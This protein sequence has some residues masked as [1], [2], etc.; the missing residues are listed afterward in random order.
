MTRQH[1]FLWTDLETTGLVPGRDAI[2]EFACILAADDREGDM[3]IIEEFTGVLRFTREARDRVLPDQFVQKMHEANG[4]W[5]EC[6]ASDTTLAEVEEFFLETFADGGKKKGIVLAGNSVHFDHK[7]LCAHMPKF[8]GCLSHRVFDVSTLSAAAMAWIGDFQP[9]R[10]K[11]HRALPDIRA[12]LD[13]A[14]RCRELFGCGFG[15]E[16]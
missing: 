13:T 2:L 5:A 3:S 15:G 1:R 8:A 7:F 4:L 12:S 14:R 6:E 10:A 16:V 9:T 11:G